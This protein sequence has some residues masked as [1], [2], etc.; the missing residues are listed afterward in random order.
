MDSQIKRE[1][2]IRALKEG[3]INDPSWQ[4]RFDEPM[5]AWAILEIALNLLDKIDPPSIGYD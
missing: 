3:I 1:I 4:E 5:P 2:I